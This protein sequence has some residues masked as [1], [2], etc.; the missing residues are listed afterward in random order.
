MVP[1]RKFTAGD[2]DHFPFYSTY[3]TVDLVCYPPEHEGFGN[4]AIETIW[5]R[6]PLAVLEYPVFKA[7][8]RD[9]IPHY[10]SLGDPAGLGRL[11]EFGGLYQL[12]KDVLAHALQQA[13]IVLRDHE[14][15]VHWTAENFA[16]LR[17]FC[18]IDT[19]SQQYIQLYDRGLKELPSPA[20]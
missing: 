7:F 11:D 13:L 4:Q 20:S 5:A 12:P 10:I 17:A 6:V 18:G 19:V 9:H 2:S 14:L 15:E 8:V 16:S 3:Q 1:D